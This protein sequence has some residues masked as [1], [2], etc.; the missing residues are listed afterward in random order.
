MPVTARNG[1]KRKS[2]NIKRRLLKGS[3]KKVLSKRYTRRKMKGGM[4]NVIGDGYRQNLIHIWNSFLV[5]KKTNNNPIII[6]NIEEKKNYVLFVIDMQNDFLDSPYPRKYFVD[7]KETDIYT[8]KN[9]KNVTFQSSDEKNFVNGVLTN[10]NFDVA[11]GESMVD[12]LMVK[13]K[14][15]L[16]D[17]N[18]KKIIISRDYHPA[19]HMSFDNVYSENYDKNPFLYQKKIDKN[20]TT[21][22]KQ[23]ENSGTFM[24]NFL[25]GTFPAHC[26][27]CHNGS[28]LIPV[29]HDYLLTLTSDESKKIK[30]VFKGINK[31]I[32]SFSAVDK[33]IIDH[34]ASNKNGYDKKPCC[35]SVSGSYFIKNKNLKY[36]VEFQKNIKDVVSYSQTDNG[37]P[38]AEYIENENNTED[39]IFEQVKYELWFNNMNI[40]NIQVCGLAGDYCVRDTI[41]ALSQKFSDTNIILLQDLT[42]YAFLPYFTIQFLP[43]HISEKKLGLTDNMVMDRDKE[44]FKN[45]SEN[46]NINIPDKDIIHYLFKKNNSADN[47]YIL[48]D[49]KDV[50]SQTYNTA[51]TLFNL[52][53]KHFI[54]SHNDILDDYDK[55]NI[56]IYIENFNQYT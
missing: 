38:Y 9:I 21:D 12:K 16:T 19:D 36:C 10:G 4:K 13:I 43:L 1:G 50:T 52:D 54:T 34:Y 48:I 18:C 44:F 42:R 15:A 7:N 26:I 30:V 40:H 49:S 2:R 8:I 14:E 23:K 29:L 55:D 24:Y 39:D 51:L 33:A 3:P 53:Y 35:S 25:T 31:E 17:P 56:K 47:E 22:P 28:S 45:I 11:Q 27:Q 5:K 46:K 37:E 20:P 41:V 32:D 6:K